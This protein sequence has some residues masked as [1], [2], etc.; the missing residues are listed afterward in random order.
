MTPHAPKW[1]TL[2][3]GCWGQVQ[4]ETLFSLYSPEGG[5]AWAS[6]RE[7]QGQHP[8]GYVLSQGLGY[9][10]ETPEQKRAEQA[11]SVSTAQEEACEHSNSV[12]VPL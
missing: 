2:R 7:D 1:V 12:E 6:W 9:N 10:A 5:G 8:H 3:K 11:I 4:P